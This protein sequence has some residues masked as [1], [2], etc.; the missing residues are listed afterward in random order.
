MN[1]DAMKKGGMHTGKMNLRLFMLNPWLYIVYFLSQ[2]AWAASP[3]LCAYLIRLL[4]DHLKLETGFGADTFYLLTALLLLVHIVAIYLIRKAGLIDVLIQFSAGRKIRNHIVRLM[5]DS[6]Q[7]KTDHVGSFLDILNYDVAALQ[8]MLLTQFDLLGQLAFLIAALVILGAINSSVTLFII[9]PILLLS[10]IIRRLSERYRC[11]Y[12]KNRDQ[13][14]AYSKFISESMSNREALQFFSNEE[15][16]ESRCRKVCETRGRS[17][18]RRAMTEA[19]PES[20]TELVGY[21]GI[22]VIMLSTAIGYQTGG[23]VGMDGGITGLTIGEFTLF[24]SFMG[25]GSL[26]L[27]LLREVSFGISE[28]EESLERIGAYLSMDGKTAAKEITAKENTATEIPEKYAEK[29]EFCGR[30][31]SEV[32]IAF[33]EF[34]LTERDIPHNFVL[35]QGD[36]V[37]VTGPNGSGKTR[38]IEAILGYAPHSGEVVIRKDK[39]EYAAMETG[40][41][42]NGNFKSPDAESSDIKIGYVSQVTH[43]FH[44]SVEENI[45]V[46]AK[47]DSATQSVSAAAVS[48]AHSISHTMNLDS[49]KRLNAVKQ[50][51]EAKELAQVKQSNPIAQ[52]AFIANID[53]SLLELRE[54]IGTDGK[55]LSEGQRQRVAIAR[56]VFEHAG[57]VILDDPFA[58]LDKENRQSILERLISHSAILV[59][60]SDD[61]NILSRVNKVIE[62]DRLCMNV[63]NV[64]TKK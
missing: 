4:F 41:T 43:L 61:I 20:S 42:K 37:A 60:A 5:I 46:F 62:M 27:N 31:A 45:S 12:A 18:L 52:A 58:F 25:Y 64:K 15:V 34:R 39:N 54:K 17:R 38:L 19:I 56:A 36:I 9:A 13:S 6:K 1:K 63:Q 10:Y 7:F 32:S 16:I 47:K 49:V 51:D 53:P 33:R 14:I 22:F 26:F 11:E 48:T 29:A 30:G 44:A 57:I 50:L 55:E 24:V 35:E 21:I 8:Y 3:F 2:L 28:G 23:V 59:I 40:D